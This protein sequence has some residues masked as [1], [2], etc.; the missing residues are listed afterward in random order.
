MLSK[1]YLYRGNIKA[2]RPIRL[3]QRAVK[4]T[5]EGGNGES[6]TSLNMAFIKEIQGTQL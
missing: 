1:S 3:Q 4:P 6:V 2:K 5:R